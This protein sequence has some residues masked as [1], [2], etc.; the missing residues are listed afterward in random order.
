MAEKF[1]TSL[2]VDKKIVSLLSKSTYQKSFSSALRELVSNAYDADS[3]SVKIEI[4]KSFKYIEIIDDGNGMTRDEFERYLTIAGTKKVND[5]TRKYK[6]KRIGQFGVGF[7]S[8]FPFCEEVEIVTT[9]EN[10]EEVLSALI[11]ATEYLESSKKV[12][13]VEDIPIYGVVT[14]DPKSRLRH[15]TRIRL[16]KPTY[17]VK[18]Y[19]SKSKTRKRESIDAWDAFDKFKW[20]LQEDLPLQFNPAIKNQSRLKFTESIGMNVFLNNKQ[21]FRNELGS[22]ILEKGKTV[23]NGIE[24]GYIFSTEYESIK[25]LE[26]RGLKIRVNNVGIGARTDFDLK[27]DRGFSRLHWISG[28]IHLSDKA[29]ENL[30]I[31]RDNFLSTPEMDEIKNYFAERLRSYAYYVESVAVAEKQL[32]SATSSSNKR[33]WVYPK[34]ETIRESIETLKDKGFKVIERKSSKSSKPIEI[35]KV[36]KQVIINSNE[37]LTR[38]SISLL[39]K[40]YEV[41]Y[42]K[43]LKKDIPCEIKDKTIVINQDY[44]LF[45]S[46]TYGNLFKKLFIFLI[47]SQK[48]N[49]SSKEFYDFVLKHIE[50]EFEDFT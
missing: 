34:A 47:I 45:N 31:A 42:N 6:R 30:S 12:E 20:E 38:E 4:D 26:A 21:L 49:R 23:I 28:E 10:S 48:T 41:I 25:P 36:K 19:F 1:K 9:S 13:Y 14:S 24:C 33:S 27:R 39:G 3:L 37:N 44:S 46:R 29:K 11:P 15:Y 50:K 8:I 35:D 22:I 43:K 5:V 32:E 18:Q 40:K 7:L 17:L 16:V 2:H